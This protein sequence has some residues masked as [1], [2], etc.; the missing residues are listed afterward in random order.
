MTVTNPKNNIFDIISQLFNFFKEWEALIENIIN[1]I[2][3]ILKEEIINGEKVCFSFLILF[4]ASFKFNT[5]T[6]PSTA[7][8]AFIFLIE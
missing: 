1:T 3:N 2:I 5:N 8:I 7:L 6:N 4:N